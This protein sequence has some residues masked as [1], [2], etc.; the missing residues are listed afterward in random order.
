MN[1]RTVDISVRIYPYQTEL[2]LEP[3]ILVRLPAVVLLDKLVHRLLHTVIAYLHLM[4]FV[5]TIYALSNEP[6][7]QTYAYVLDVAGD[8]DGGTR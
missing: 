8:C 3:P 6:I 7:Y 4:Y 5:L 1:T 2:Q